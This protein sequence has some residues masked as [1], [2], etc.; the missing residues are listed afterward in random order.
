MGVLGATGGA[1]GHCMLARTCV[2]CL[3]VSRC[4]ALAAHGEG[5]VDRRRDDHQ[6]QQVGNTNAAAA[7]MANSASSG[8]I[9]FCR[10]L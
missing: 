9:M 5:H 10:N 3:R 4:P 8:A 1:A 7:T 6:D 2:P